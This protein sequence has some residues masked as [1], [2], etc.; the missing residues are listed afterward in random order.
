M[1][2]YFPN[3]TKN[4]FQDLYQASTSKLYASNSSIYHVGNDKHTHCRMRTLLFPHF[5]F[6]WNSRK[7][8]KIH[9]Y[10]LDVILDY[11]SDGG[12]SKASYTL[13]F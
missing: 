3:V 7:E 10:V 5:D 9:V 13:G 1:L 12:K 2:K 8:K 11:I 4:V 6:S